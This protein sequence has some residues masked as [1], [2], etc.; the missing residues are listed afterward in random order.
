MYD[1]IDLRMKHGLWRDARVDY[2]DDSSKINYVYLDSTYILYSIIILHIQFIYN[3]HIRHTQ[4]YCL[5]NIS[6]T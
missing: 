6:N 4:Y 3:M 2:Y 5:P 1:Y